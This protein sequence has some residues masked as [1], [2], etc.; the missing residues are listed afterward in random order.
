MP[1]SAAAPAAPAGA[2]TR[3]GLHLLRVLPLKGLHLLRV[4]TL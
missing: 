2:R 3:E 4:L 1:R